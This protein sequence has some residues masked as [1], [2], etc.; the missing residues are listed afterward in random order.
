MVGTN[1]SICN[2]AYSMKIESIFPFLAWFK[3]ITKDSL[4]ADFFAGL[5]GAVIV[6]PQGIAFATIAGLPPEYGLYTAMVTPI[7]A[8]LFGSSR[9]LVSGPTTAISIVVFSAISHHAEPGTTEFVTLAL[10]L[11]F[12]AGV[13]QFGFGLARL[14]SLV[15]FVSHTVVIGFTAGAAILIATSQMKHVTALTVPRGESFLHTWADLF[16]GIS[17]INLIVLSIAVV[18]LI[19]AIASKKILPK[20]PYLL[21]GMI[22]GSVLALFLKDYSDGIKLVGEIPAHLPP[23][24]SPEF[25][26]AT[27]KML[28]PEAFAVSLL[29][30]IEAV[31]ISRA[32]A[33]KSNQRIDANQEFIGQGL[34]NII[35]SFFSSYAGSGSFTRSGINYDAGAKTPLS[36]IFAAI[37]LMIIVLLIAPLTA[38]LPIAAMGGIILLVAYNLVDFHHIKQT[39]TFSKSESSILLTTFFATLFLELEFAIYLGVLLSLILFLAKTSTPR[40]PTLSVD[41]SSDTR[42]LINIQKQPVNQCPQLKIIRIDMSIYF[43]SV[44]H[45]QKRITKIAENERIYHILIVASGINFID[46]AGAEAL[47]SEN[48]QLKNLGGGLYFVGLKSNVYEF[49]AKSCFIKK[50]GNNHFFDSKSQ[51]FHDLYKRL[52]RSVCSTCN[53]LIFKECQ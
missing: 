32:V 49:A 21:I 2:E 33:T 42:K 14:G 48:N 45:I 4:K 36:A 40:I 12:L 51:A 13:Y 22:G 29:G 46:L 26:M 38:Y 23:L 19:I 39:L 7:I 47:V 3:L 8:A 31:S 24:S 1:V 6:L 18:T 10:T 44:N 52:D 15:N 28:A 20:S 37:L 5:T 25:S 16:Q 11:T 30:L 50:I 41:A 17:D 43:G 53:A 35:G 34:S 27:I 9:H